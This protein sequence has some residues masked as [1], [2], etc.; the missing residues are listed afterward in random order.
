MSSIIIQAADGSGDFTAYVV[1]PKA[2]PAGVVVVIQEIFGVNQAMRDTAAWIADLGFIAVCPDLFWRIEPGIDITDKSDAEWKRAFEL[3]QAFDQVKGIEDLKTTVAACR[4]LPGANGKVATIGYCLGGR[5][6]FMM[7][8]Q[9][10]ADANISYYGVGL[11]GLLADL[12]KV[13]NPLLVHI[14]DKDAFF[15]PEGRAAVAA[16]LQ[17][18]PNAVCHVYPNADHAFARVN[19]IHWDGRSATIANGRSAVLLAEVLG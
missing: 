8:E 15:P 14:A 1:E 18:H 5:L 17:G 11:D 3:F 12:P 7:A 2:K 13:K 6:A 10:D 4:T 9:S 16:A 19:G